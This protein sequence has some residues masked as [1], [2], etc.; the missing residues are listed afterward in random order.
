MRDK[1]KSTAIVELL[2]AFWTQYPCK[3]TSEGDV[4]ELCGVA[5]IILQEENEMKSTGI[6]VGYL[7]V[8]LALLIAL[9]LS[10]FLVFAHNEDLPMLK[11][12]GLG[13]LSYWKSAK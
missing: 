12:T 7:L 4:P 6:K 11:S 8:V 9:V 10:L 2:R 1:D 13:M 3:K 5:L